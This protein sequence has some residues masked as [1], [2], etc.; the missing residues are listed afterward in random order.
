MRIPS[1]SIAE[2]TSRAFTTTGPRLGAAPACPQAGGACDLYTP[3]EA[4][5]AG[6]LFQRLAAAARTAVHAPEEQVAGAVGG[7]VGA[8]LSQT[9]G[10]Q[11]AQ[12]RFDRLEGEESHAEATV[13]SARR[14]TN[15]EGTTQTVGAAAV[16][17]DN[18]HLAAEGTVTTADGQSFHFTLDYLRYQETSVGAT[19]TVATAPAP[20]PDLPASS[21]EAQLTDVHVRRMKRLLAMLPPAEGAPTGLV[22]TTA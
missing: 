13:A 10:I 1:S 12:V 18:L 7:Q 19:S 11:V 15:G 22:N 3:S 6:S 17:V 5:G 9:F 14:T 4:G 21:L 2:A 16:A 8:I 20:R